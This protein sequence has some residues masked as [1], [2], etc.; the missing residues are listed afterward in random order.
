MLLVE[1]G[2]RDPLLVPHQPSQNL[3]TPRQARHQRWTRSFT[4]D[5]SPG[6]DHHLTSSVLAGHCSAGWLAYIKMVEVSSM[7]KFSSPSSFQGNGK[8]RYNGVERQP[9]ILRLFNLKKKSI[10][11]LLAMTVT[12]VVLNENRLKFG[13]FSGQGTCCVIGDNW[14]VNCSTHFNLFCMHLGESL[15]VA[16]S[17]ID[18]LGSPCFI[19]AYVRAIH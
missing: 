3:F 8:W 15:T 13:V 19:F 17:N 9:A 1:V 5:S 18:C 4:Q 12:R 11:S 14:L 6:E 10:S 7:W 2:R 16:Y